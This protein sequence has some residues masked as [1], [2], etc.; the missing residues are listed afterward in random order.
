MTGQSLYVLL[1]L[2][3][4]WIAK[5]SWLGPFI[6]FSSHVNCLSPTI[7]AFVAGTPKAA[8]VTLASEYELEPLLSSIH[9]LEDTFNNRYNYDWIF[10]S[11]EPLS[12]E[13][14]RRTSNATTATCIYELVRQKDEN[15]HHW[16]RCCSSEGMPSQTSQEAPSPTRGDSLEPLRT[17]RQLQRW[18]NGPFAR[19][20]RL[21]TYDW[22]WRIEPGVSFGMQNPLSSVRDD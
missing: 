3:L 6:C 19:E 20:K 21:Q 5:T 10:F 14:R 8:L 12:D 17:F 11:M 7:D 18:N 9:Q 16:D 22:F 2:N 4:I 13:F 1:L 15:L